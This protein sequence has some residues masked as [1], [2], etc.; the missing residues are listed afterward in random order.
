MTDS[1]GW[2]SLRNWNKEFHP[3]ESE[4]TS[5]QNEMSSTQT[6][7]DPNKNAIVVSRYNEDPFWVLTDPDFESFSKIIYNKGQPL[8]LT[9]ENPP[10]PFSGPVTVKTL[11]NVGREGHTYLHHIVENYDHLA[12]VTVFLPASAN[13]SELRNFRAHEIVQ[14]VKDTGSSVFL[15]RT[16]DRTVQEYFADFEINSWVGLNKDNASTAQSTTDQSRIARPFNK[17]YA[18]FFE[19]INICEVSFNGIFAVSREHILQHS[20]EYY[21]ALLSALSHSSNP[22]DGHYLERS[23][24]AVFHPLPKECLIPYEYTDIVVPEQWKWILVYSIEKRNKV[25]AFFEWLLQVV[26]SL[27]V[28]RVLALILVV[29][30]YYLLVWYREKMEPLPG[31]EEL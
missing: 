11:P 7:V 14:R 20:K 2:E 4:E 19:G 27:I 25:I 10:G 9:P 18:H 15:C 16:L 31:K 1:G 28:L 22:E 12:P 17:W 23:W 13:C 21:E 24:V 3:K 26:K 5:I 6:P 8:E 29:P 30:M